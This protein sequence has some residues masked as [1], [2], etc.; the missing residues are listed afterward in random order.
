MYFKV[1]SFVH[2][3]FRQI[4]HSFVHSDVL[5]TRNLIVVVAQKSLSLDIV[6]VAPKSQSL[7]SNSHITVFKRL[8]DWILS[9]LT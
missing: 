8:L 9:N 2:S 4:V 3:A 7:D 5:Y 6:A 1:H